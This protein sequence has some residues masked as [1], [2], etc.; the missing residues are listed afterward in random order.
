[1]VFIT[2]LT[3]WHISWKWFLIWYD[4]LII[5]I[6]SSFW[7]LTWPLICFLTK[8]YHPHEEPS[9]ISLIRTRHICQTVMFWI[10]VCY[11]NWRRLCGRPVSRSWNKLVRQN[12]TPFKPGGFGAVSKRP[13]DILAPQIFTYIY[14]KLK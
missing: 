7:I 14:N 3:R 2:Q 10:T 11:G 6:R 1:M 4:Y 13:V 12:Q 8:N 5:I 9:V